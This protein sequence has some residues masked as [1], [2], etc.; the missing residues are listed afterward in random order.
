M[1]IDDTIAVAYIDNR[2]A[3]STRMYSLKG[4]RLGIYA[5]HGSLTVRNAR[6]SREF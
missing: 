4:T 1:I 6:I 2:I 5:H 3:F